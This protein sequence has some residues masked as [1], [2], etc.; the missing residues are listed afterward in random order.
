[1]YGT[2]AHT[3]RGSNTQEYPATS[4]LQLL[5]W[6]EKI[7]KLCRPEK[8][9][10]CDGSQQEYDTLCQELVNNKTFVKLNPVTRPNCF[11]A[12][13]DERDTYRPDNAAFVCCKSKED[14]G[15]SNAWVAP[16]EMRAK[17]TSL[18]AGCMEGRT[19]YIVPFSMGPIGSAYSRICVEITD[20]IYNVVNMRIV[21]RMG[22]AA[23]KQLRD[24]MPF[25]ALV[26][27]VGC[28]LKEGDADVPWP[29]NPDK[30]VVAHF[31]EENSVWSYGSQFGGNAMLSKRSVGLRLASAW[32][33]HNKSILTAHCS[34]LS[35]TSPETK[36][37]SS[38]LVSQV[39]LVR[40]TFPSLCPP[41]PVGLNV[42]SVRKFLGCA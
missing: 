41:S 13:T 4:H 33:Q 10:W 28:P 27:S 25:T 12:R 3:P 22:T 30:L 24:K 35:L 42:A 7:R 39:E 36:N 29:C 23:L 37:I 26:H 31:T 1:M 8:V 32:G 9:H 17:L 38:L 15:P 11:L 20:S 18:F 21:T 14:A 2:P 6:V 16:D 19:M 40:P 5:S 34:V